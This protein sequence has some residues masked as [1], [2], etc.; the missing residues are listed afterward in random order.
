M[1]LL[2]C[3]IVTSDTASNYAN[4]QNGGLQSTVAYNPR[5]YPQVWAY[6]PK[7]ISLKRYFDVI[8]NQI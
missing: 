5:R 8:F 4:T 7:K 6:K 1:E 3:T 2:T